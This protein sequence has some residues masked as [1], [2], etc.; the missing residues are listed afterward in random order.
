MLVVRVENPGTIHSVQAMG[1]DMKRAIFDHARLALTGLIALAAANARAGELLTNGGFESPYLGPFNFTYPG[2]AS[3]PGNH[4]EALIFPNPTLDSWTYNASVPI[5]GGSALVNGQTGSDWYGPVPPAGFAGDQFAALQNTG[6]LT[7]DFTS[8]GGDL[9]LNFLSGGRPDNFGTEGGDQTYLVELDGS[10][11][12]SFSTA[13]GQVFTLETVLLRGVSAGSHTLT[14]QGLSAIGD[15]SA[16]LDNVSLVP[17]PE[18]ATWTLMAAGFSA[19]GAATYWRRKRA[20][21]RAIGS[22]LTANE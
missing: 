22:G 3:Y 10:T 4:P 11:V 21:D 20:T 12:A 1:G 17:V 18:P 5:S 15:E 14:F 8:P 16:F 7:Q 19:L 13:S 6:S 9:T 2:F